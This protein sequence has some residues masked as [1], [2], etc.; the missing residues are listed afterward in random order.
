MNAMKNVIRIAGRFYED[1]V[2]LKARLG[3]SETTLTRSVRSKGLPPPIVLGKRRLY[4]SVRVDEW[5]LTQ[6]RMPG[7]ETVVADNAD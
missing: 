1:A 5:A 4:D 6:I 3:I 2:E 7:V